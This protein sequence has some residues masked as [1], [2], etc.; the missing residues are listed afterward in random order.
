VVIAK[1]SVEQKENSVS[2]SMIDRTYWLIN[3]SHQKMLEVTEE[4]T[5]DQFCWRPGPQAPPIGWHLWHIARWADHVQASFPSSGNE[6]RRQIWEED[7]LA[8][9]L[10]LDTS[11]LGPCQAGEDMTH[12][13]ATALPKQIGQAAILDYARRC[14]AKHEGI[15]E[16]F[17]QEDLDK[18]R[19]SPYKYAIT[20]DGHVIAN[21]AALT[22]LGSD[23]P[24]HMNHVCRHLGM[25]E[26]I[27][28]V[29][30]MNGTATV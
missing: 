12:D 28:G 20:E 7:E 4:L 6:P 26:G 29:L 5:E 3:W 23:L 18:M 1:L 10:E 17:T 21:P 14:F 24:W 19:P 11:T 15:Q 25:I 16:W 2:D 9:R 30:E 8:L 22:M 13:A 27:R